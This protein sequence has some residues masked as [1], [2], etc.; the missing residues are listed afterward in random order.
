MVSFLDIP[1][2]ILVAVI[3]FV[4]IHDVLNLRKVSESDYRD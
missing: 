4:D 1:D 3:A 2:E